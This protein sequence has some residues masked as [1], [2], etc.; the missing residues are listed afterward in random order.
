MRLKGVFL[1]AEWRWLAMLNYEVE[2]SLLRPY[3]PPGTELDTW[4]GRAF[5]S[6]V[7][8]RFLATRILG[9][10]VPGHR[11]FDEVN[12]RLYVRRRAPEGWRRGVAFIRELVP[13][14]GLAWVARAFYGEPYAAVPMRHAINPDSGLVSYAWL[15]SGGWCSLNLRCHGLPQ[16]PKDDSEEAFIVEHYWG[17]TARPGGLLSEYSVEHPRWK[18]FATTHASLSGE[19]GSLYGPNFVATLSAP[20][21]S[22]F[23]AEG[24]KVLVRRPVVLRP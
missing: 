6:L 5:V 24:S 15:W 17:Y 10:G 11:D 19:L 23:V 14:K 1:S 20:P 2:P 16:L 9:L 12:L 22:A 7:G 13:R 3:L 18:V 4:N 8:F 21:H